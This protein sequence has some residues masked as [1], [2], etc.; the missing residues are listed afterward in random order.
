MLTMISS[1]EEAFQTLSDPSNPTWGAAFAYLSSHPE[2]ASLMIETFRETLEQMGV[3]PTGTDPASGEPSFSLRDIA[4]A[5]G[6][7]ETDLDD[8]VAGS[9]SSGEGAAG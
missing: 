3:A 1:V 6:V 4:R 2:T 5:L 7:S 9:I 8:A